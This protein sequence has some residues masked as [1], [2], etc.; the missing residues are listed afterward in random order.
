M[1]LDH[2]CCKV[3]TG[4]QKTTYSTYNLDKG[5]CVELEHDVSVFQ[6]QNARQEDIESGAVLAYYTCYT[7]TILYLVYLLNVSNGCYAYYTYN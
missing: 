6:R 3:A 1:S 2:E 5:G 4:M 7:F